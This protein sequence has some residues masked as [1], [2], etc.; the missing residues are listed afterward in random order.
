MRDQNEILMSYNFRVSAAGLEFRVSKIRNIEQEVEV[1]TV[2][3]G[4]CN[5]WVHALAKPPSEPKRLVFERGCCSGL[6]SRG[7]QLMVGLPQA[8]PMIIAVYDRKNQNIQKVYLVTGWR[9][10]KW[11]IGELDAISGGVLLETA[12][13]VYETLREMV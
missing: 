6:E 5:G 1:E 7:L 10:V 11:Q 13:A 9:I 8:E 12:E 4:G 3:E 2:R